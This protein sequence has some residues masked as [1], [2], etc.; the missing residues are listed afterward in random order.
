MEKRT[1]LGCHSVHKSRL[2]PE[3]LPAGEDFGVWI[4]VY[5]DKTY[6]ARAEIYPW[7]RLQEQMWDKRHREFKKLPEAE[8]QKRIKEQEAYWKKAEKDNK[9]I[10]TSDWI[11]PRPSDI[12]EQIACKL[13]FAYVI[14]EKEARIMQL[15]MIDA[16]QWVLHTKMPPKTKH[17]GWQNISSIGMFDHYEVKSLEG[18]IDML[19]GTAMTTSKSISEAF[20]VMHKKRKEV[21]S[22]SI[23]S[24]EDYL[25]YAKE[26]E[27]KMVT[28]KTNVR[29]DEQ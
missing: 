5:L 23:K 16:L 24:H 2:K 18:V 3:F 20:D 19:G 22:N 17:V 7:K 27:K 14:A 28:V 21:S 10:D 1:M 6:G 26:L 9:P 29:D 12:K 15:G 25:A 4:E 13:F 8:Q 11:R